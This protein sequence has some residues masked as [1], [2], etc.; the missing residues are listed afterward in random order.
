MT[1]E[2]FEEQVA[3]HYAHCDECDWDGGNEE[4]ESDAKRAAK[5]HNE[6]CPY[7][8]AERDGEEPDLRTE[9]ERFQDSLDETIG[10]WAA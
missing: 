7:V 4:E 2:V 5:T 3:V 6:T 10:R 9:R 1:A 8:I